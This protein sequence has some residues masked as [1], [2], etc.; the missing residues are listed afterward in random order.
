MQPMH[1]GAPQFPPPGVHPQYAQIPP[2]PHPSRAGGPKGLVAG[3]AEQIQGVAAALDEELYRNPNRVSS[4]LL[5]GAVA[6]SILGALFLTPMLAAPTVF[7]VGCFTAAAACLGGRA[8][9]ASRSRAL[10]AKGALPLSLELSLLELAHERGGVL[11]VAQSARELKISLDEAEKALSRLAK[12][13]HAEMDVDSQ[14]EV[15]YRLSSGPAN[16]PAAL[17]AG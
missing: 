14:G 12:R 8:V 9:V 5:F 13:G 4:L 10:D 11:S 7:V 16:P 15:R 17:P 3:K 6:L 1:P 2:R